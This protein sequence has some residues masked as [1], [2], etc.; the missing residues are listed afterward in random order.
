MGMNASGPPVNPSPPERPPESA[1]ADWLARYAEL[2]EFKRQHGDVRVL[3][4]YFDREPL[5]LWIVQQCLLKA[6]GR[7]SPGREELLQAIGLR[8]RIKKQDKLDLQNP[9]WE[10]VFAAVVEYHR[11]HGHFYIPKDDPDYDLL[12]NWMT[13]QRSLAAQGALAPERRQRLEAIGFPWRA[14][15]LA[16]QIKWDAKFAALIAFQQVHGHFNVPTGVHES[17]GNQNLYVWIDNLR[18]AFGAGRL[19]PERRRR[20]EAIGFP[21]LKPPHAEVLWNQWLAKLT[22]YHQHYGQCPIKVQ[23]NKYKAL[24]NWVKTQRLARAAGELSPERIARLDALGFVWENPNDCDAT[25]EARYAE[26]VEFHKTFHHCDVAVKW[27]PNL[28]LG[29]WVRHQVRLYLR[30]DLTPEQRTRLD[31]LGFMNRE[32]KSLLFHAHGKNLRPPK[33]AP[34][35]PSV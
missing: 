34:S 18:G 21:F 35:A 10:K 11:L 28:A 33:I 31:A 29:R 2:Y 24:L 19:E 23:G 1:D 5:R 12:H 4:L 6:A 7:L 14:Q 13:S 22:N 9:N 16:Q 20:L 15:G 25:W 27:R 8:W 26:L 32:P 3:S 17:T 30:G